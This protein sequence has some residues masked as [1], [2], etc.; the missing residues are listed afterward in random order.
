[1]KKT[2]LLLPAFA[3]VLAGCTLNGTANPSPTPSM[4]DDSADTMEDDT[5]MNAE[6]SMTEEDGVMVGG[7]MMVPSKN[8]AENAMQSSEHT[9][10]ISAVQAAGL[11]A[12]LSQEGPFTV[13]APTNGAFNK[14]PAGTVA[15]LVKPENKAQLTNIL[16]YHVVAGRYTSADLKDGMQLKTV[17]GGMLTIRMQGDTWMVEDETGAKATVTTADVI[18]SNGV[19]FVVDT[20]LM[21]Q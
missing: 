18:S 16:T 8:I 14:L 19:T 1:M 6:T 15:N 3:L 2:L 21:P 20:V 9:T 13:F 12:T 5:M 11:A 4:M 7:A 17:Q 10:L